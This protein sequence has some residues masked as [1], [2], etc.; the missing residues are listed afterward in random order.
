M[1]Q[2]GEILGVIIAITVGTTI[3]T[4]ATILLQQ[5]VHAAVTTNQVF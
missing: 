2:K 4:I 3:S 5:Q 1:K